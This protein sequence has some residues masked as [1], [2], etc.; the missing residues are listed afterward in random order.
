[1]MSYEDKLNSF[2][3]YVKNQLK[4]VIPQEIL[5]TISDDDLMEAGRKNPET[6]LDFYSKEQERH[7]IM[8]NSSNESIFNAFANLKHL[9]HVEQQEKELIEEFLA[10]VKP[11]SIEKNEKILSALKKFEKYTQSI[12]IEDIDKTVTLILSLFPHWILEGEKYSVFE[13]EPLNFI[14]K[15]DSVC[16][17]CLLGEMLHSY[18][19]FFGW[20][21]HTPTGDILED[22]E[23]GED[24]LETFELK[25]KDSLI[26]LLTSLFAVRFGE[27]SDFLG[28][29]Q[30]NRSFNNLFFDFC[31]NLWVHIMSTPL[32]SSWVYGKEHAQKSLDQREEIKELLEGIHDHF[33]T[34]FQNCSKTNDYTSF[35]QNVKSYIHHFDK[36]QLV[37]LSHYGFP[38]KMSRN[39]HNKIE[40]IILQELKA[41]A[42]ID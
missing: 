38:F 17:G 24:V 39:L 1:M 37:I 9:N 25:A 2:A 32:I 23:I 31:E 40:K 6:G 7:I 22:T 3:Q 27:T 8:E 16:M 35:I 5:E 41:K 28:K 20:A 36:T 29:L 14:M 19:T 33:V 15:S 11:I 30:K 42:E 10:D 4:G 34:E 13:K 21:K 12:K 26:D 18:K